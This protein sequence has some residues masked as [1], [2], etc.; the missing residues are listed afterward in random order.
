MLIHHS[1]IKHILT[2]TAMECSLPVPVK[3]FAASTS[4]IDYPDI[5]LL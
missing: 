5:I 1:F 4:F 2:S 3:Q